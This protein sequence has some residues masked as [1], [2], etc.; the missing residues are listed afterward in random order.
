MSV[1]QKLT[2]GI[3]LLLSQLICAPVFGDL[4]DSQQSLASRPAILRVGPASAPPVIDGELNDKCWQ[5]ASMASGFITIDGLWATEQTTAYVAYDD[6]CLY[7]AFRCNEPAPEKIAKEAKTNDTPSVF[8]DDSVEFFLDT[9]HDRTTYYHFCINAI[10]ARYEAYCDAGK[11]LRNVDWNPDWELKTRIGAQCWTVEMRIPFKSLATS[12][13]PP[14]ARWGINLCRSCHTGKFAEY[15]SWAMISG[16]FNQPGK[17]GEL[18]FGEYPAVSY[19]VISMRD[20]PADNELKIRFR[21][22]KKSSLALRAQWTVG[23][24]S[25]IAVVR[26]GPK[27]EK[28]VCLAVN[29]D[30]S[31]E[32]GVVID[33]ALTAANAKTGEICDFRKAGW[34]PSLPMEMSLDRYYYYTPDVQ[35]VRVGFTRKIKNGDFLKV[36]AG[37]KPDEKPVVSRQISLAP[38]QDDYNAS[39]DIT[40]WDVGR[41]VVSAHL[42]DKSKKTLSSV[43][44]VFIKKTIEPAKIPAPAP[45][46]SLRSDGI[47]LLDEKPFCP[48]FASTPNQDKKSP[49]VK[50]CFNVGY[51]GF[52]D[53]SRPLERTGIGLP[54]WTREQ[55]FNGGDVFMLLPEEEKMLENIRNIV[56][57]RKADPLLLYWFMSYEASIPMY[58]G[59]EN[60][61]RLNNA[62][63]LRKISQFVKSIDPDHPTALEIDSGNWADYKDAA[64]IIEVAMAASYAKHLIPNFIKDIDG[65]R[66][67]LGPG[68]PFILWIG[69][70]IPSADRRTAEEI[71]CASYLALMHGADGIIFHMGHEGI[72]P[73]MTRHWSVYTGLSREVE[74]LFPILTASRQAGRYKIAIDSTGIDYCVREYNNRLYLV[75]VNTSGSLVKARISFADAS[76]I[77]KRINVL[78]E[79]REIEL[80]GNGFVDVFTAFEPHVYEI[81]P[82][83]KLP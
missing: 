50:D 67:A 59:K 5:D 66:N 51:A 39:F 4:P 77:S 72:S 24:S 32:S 20:S 78:F 68:K 54:G 22:G 42:Q 47:I 25:K 46:V 34:E 2:I 31:S 21:N 49:L 19:S 76:V 58:R 38:G 56:T 62:A 41:Y 14:G 52:G 12:F 75:A 17:F 44:R 73:S 74:D 48:F 28:E 16:G 40:D 9:N 15:A 26:L 70:S 83:D 71:R 13:P 10:G 3:G 6:A 65:V 29:K 69:S 43:A 81:I 18:V 30:M 7:I 1:Q 23:A 35:Q 55:G 61:V 33:L 11:E 27:K 53:V 8:G 36:E 64:D 45:K 82:G 37:K 80:T 60:G 63:E 79:N 57:A